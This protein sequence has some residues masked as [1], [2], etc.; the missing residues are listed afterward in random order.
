MKYIT[1]ITM[2]T[3]ATLHP[4][5][6]TSTIE[7]IYGTVHS[8]EYATLP[9]ALE[10]AHKLDKDNQRRRVSYHHDHANDLTYYTFTKDA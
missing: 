4:D 2:D 7:R 8:T 5:Y 3:R 6:K 9:Q 10:L 1:V